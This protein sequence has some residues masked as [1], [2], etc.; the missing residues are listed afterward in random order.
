MKKLLFLIGLVFISVLAFSQDKESTAYQVG[1]NLG[2]FFGLVFP[3]IILV[4]SAVFIFI[5][6][7]K[8]KKA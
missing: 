4:V 8:K 3:L 7:K 1:N 6:S 5:F 2:Y